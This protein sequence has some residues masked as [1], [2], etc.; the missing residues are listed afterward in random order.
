M[1]IEQRDMADSTARIASQKVE[2]ANVR[3]KMYEDRR[4][5][6]EREA[7]EA[8]KLQNQALEQI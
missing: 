7:A 5:K 2:E 4:L 6:A 8:L 3:V 1:A